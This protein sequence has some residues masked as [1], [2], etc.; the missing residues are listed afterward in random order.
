MYCA[1]SGEATTTLVSHPRLEAQVGEE[2][3]TPSYH[4]HYRHYQHNLI[5]IKI[6]FV[7]LS[8]EMANV[9]FP[10]EQLKHW[11]QLMGALQLW[12]CFISTPEKEVVF[13]RKLDSRLFS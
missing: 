3:S 6:C 11:C 12:Q 1:S 13:C 9:H 8:I 5:Q 2:R 10:S 7:V 4:H